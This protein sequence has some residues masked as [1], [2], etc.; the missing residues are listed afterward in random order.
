MSTAALFRRMG[1]VALATPR[2]GRVLARLGV[3][4]ATG[5]T[6]GKAATE[7]SPVLVTKIN[8][9]LSPQEQAEL[10]TAL[11][12]APAALAAASQQPAADESVDAPTALQLRRYFLQKMLPMVGFGFVDNCIMLTAGDAIDQT[13]GATL[14]IST[15]AAAGLGNLVSDVMG[16]GLSSYVE[17]VASKIG[18]PSPNLTM[19]QINSTQCRWTVLAANVVGIS[20]GCLLGMVPLLFLTTDVT[21]AEHIFKTLDHDLS[22]RCSIAEIEPFLSY[23]GLD[24]DHPK[25]LSKVLGIGMDELSEGLTRDQFSEVWT[26]IESSRHDDL[27]ALAKEIVDKRA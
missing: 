8:G 1:A 2:R 13:L 23:L 21:T 18:I 14:Q 19:A 4:W 24:A 17:A 15:L 10:A 9:L 27:R 25:E 3:R 5:G 16:L 7:L 22:G 20:I 26:A 11:G 6:T 12:G